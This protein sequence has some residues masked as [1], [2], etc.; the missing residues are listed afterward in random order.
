MNA[1]SLNSKAQHALTFGAHE[2]KT[3]KRDSQLWLSGTEVGTLLEYAA[4]DK[5]IKQIYSA[6]ADEFTST[7]TKIISVATA[8]G[9]QAVR[10]F[11]LR[12]AH[13]LAM[14]A[15]TPVA[16]AFRA[17][18][19]DILDREVGNKRI[20]DAEA[21]RLNAVQRMELEGLCVEAD[22]LSNWWKKYKDGIEIL[23][24]KMFGEVFEQFLFM[25]AR[26]RSLSKELGLKS[27]HKYFATYPWGA[28]SREKQIHRERC[29]GMK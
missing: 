7:M 22:F 17:W 29:Q 11:S 16:K 25:G 2:V 3:I 13:L 24:P 28:D 14:F 20:A 10:F 1:T 15:R 5:A 4:P 9:K 6:H 21:T 12:G 23:N 18:V 27:H 8:G 26:A 19:L